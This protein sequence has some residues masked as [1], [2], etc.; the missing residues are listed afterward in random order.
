MF[1]LV[2]FHFISKATVNEKINTLMLD[3]TVKIVARKVVQQ[4]STLLANHVSFWGCPTPI[5]TPI[6]NWGGSRGTGEEVSTNR[7][8]APPSPSLEALLREIHML[9]MQQLHSECER[10]RVWPSLSRN[11][12]ISI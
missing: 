9:V 8:F 7:N 11:R 10:G 2:S 4:F 5:K 1:W 3:P 6:N 12:E